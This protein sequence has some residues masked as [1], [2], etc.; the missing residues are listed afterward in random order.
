MNDGLQAL[1]KNKEGI[2]SSKWLWS[3]TNWMGEKYHVYIPDMWLLSK[4]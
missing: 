1:V 2:V 3:F 4:G